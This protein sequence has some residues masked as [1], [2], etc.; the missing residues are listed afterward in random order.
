MPAIL[1]A[2]RQPIPLEVQWLTDK[3]HVGASDR[4][5]IREFRR[6]M[7]HNAKARAL[8][9]GPAGREARRQVYADA[10]AAHAE[11]RALF[12]FVT[13]SI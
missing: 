9:A 5:V 8:Y 13:G 7:F 4:D 12:T 2:P 3:L 11:N 6:R 10:L 1:P